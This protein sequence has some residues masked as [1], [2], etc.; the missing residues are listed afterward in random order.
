MQLGYQNEVMGSL[1]T[2]EKLQDWFAGLKAKHEIEVDEAV[3]KKLY[4]QLSAEEWEDE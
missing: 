1:E 2:D 3:F 4:K